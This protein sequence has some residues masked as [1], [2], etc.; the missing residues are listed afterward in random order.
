MNLCRLILLTESGISSSQRAGAEI[1]DRLQSVSFDI[2]FSLCHRLQ[3][4]TL[5]D[6]L[7]FIRDN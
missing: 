3:E 5:V 2:R 7:Y 4:G 1:A 6:T